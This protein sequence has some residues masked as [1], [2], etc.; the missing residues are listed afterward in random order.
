M[1]LHDIIRNDL[2]TRKPCH[3]LSQKFYADRDVFNLDLDLIFYKEWIFAGHECEIPKPGDYFTMQI[4][5]YA[6]ILVRDQVGELRAHHNTCRHR[7]F[8]ICAATHGQVKRR[9][10]CPYHQWSYGLDGAL[11]GARETGDGFD[12]RAHGLKSAHVESIGGH[13]FVCVAREAPSIAALKMQIEPYLMPFD[14]RNAKVAFESRIVEHGNWKLVMENNREC[15]HCAASH[16]ELTRTFPESTLHSGAGDEAERADLER[17]VE[18]CEAMGLP[19]RFWIS[20][21]NQCRVMRMRLLDDARS[22]TITGKPAVTGKTLGRIPAEPNIGDVLL[23]HF[24]STWSHFTADHA[25]S[26]RVLPVSPTETEL[27]SKWLVPKD[28]IE[29]VDYNLKTLTEVWLA[30]N[31]QDR[32]LVAQNQQGIASPAYEPGPYAPQQEHGV[33]QFIDWYCATMSKRLE[34]ASKLKVVA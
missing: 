33:I 16:P 2:K 15:Y 17:L 5:A 27:V 9:F 7:G 13:I 10:V 26:F 31:E 24:P 22:M 29:G 6:L 30:T 4:G 12:P 34:G 8:K 21:D 28:A 18:A 23:Y 32:N 11:V 14:L 19:G 1:T 25:L 20:D 3:A